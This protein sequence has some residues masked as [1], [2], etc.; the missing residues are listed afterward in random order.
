MRNTALALSVDT[1]LHSNHITLFSEKLSA[2]FAKIL[3]AV[4]SMPVGR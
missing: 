4:V 1:V 2:N 3:A